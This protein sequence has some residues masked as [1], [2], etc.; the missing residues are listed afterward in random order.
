MTMLKVV[1][2][3]NTWPFDLKYLSI[4]YI[5]MEAIRS[6]HWQ[7]MSTKAHYGAS[8]ISDHERLLCLLG[9]KSKQT[10]LAPLFLEFHS[11]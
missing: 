10:F 2:Q 3:N 9:Q 6:G 8:V 4:V 5:Q 7:R 1:E 11:E